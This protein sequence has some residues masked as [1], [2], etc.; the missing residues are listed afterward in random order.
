MGR[1]LIFGGSGFLGRHAVSALI[2]DRRTTDLVS[3][4]RTAPDGP[5]TVRHDLVTGDTADLAD[6]LTRVRPDAVVC[7]AGRLS[8][9]DADLVRGNVLVT[10]KLLD[11]VAA[12][13]PDA[14]LVLLGSAAEYGVV[15]FGQPVAED[16]PTVPVSAYGI[17]RLASTRLA[18]LAAAAGRVDAVVLRVFNPIGPGLPDDN[19]LGRAA[20]RLRA[21][22]AA[23]D[24]HIALGPLGACRDFVDVRDVGAAIAAAALA[25]RVE[26][27]IL[28]VGSGVATPARTAVT[29]LRRVAR[30]GGEVREADP[31]PARS[32][33]VDWIAAD[34]TRAGRE[35]AWAPRYDLPAA[36]RSIWRHREAAAAR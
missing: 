6:L 31:A 23:G 34:I 16:A 21:A 5:G 7:C 14:R 10:A 32:G 11:A 18:A 19:L 20:A 15:P 29:L 1:V 3:A 28:N 25:G 30:Y 27:R 33:A 12:A 26:E 2:G 8:G 35:L 4:G 24:G 13:R 9:T 17:T 36:V 22:L